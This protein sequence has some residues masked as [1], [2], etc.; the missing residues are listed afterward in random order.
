MVSA[1]CAP[2]APTAILHSARATAHPEREGR[3]QASSH[4]ARK[5]QGL[6][7]S[8]VLGRITWNAYLKPKSSVLLQM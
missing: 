7:K 4:A 6:S 8:R 1:V 3:G 5:W 2:E